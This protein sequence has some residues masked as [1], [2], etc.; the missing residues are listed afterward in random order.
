M[1]TPEAIP[2]PDTVAWLLDGGPS[3]RYSTLTRLLGEPAGGVA[4]TQAR[5]RIMVEGTVPAILAAQRDDGHSR[6]AA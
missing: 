5:E 1:G 4:A 2:N 6:G 3:V